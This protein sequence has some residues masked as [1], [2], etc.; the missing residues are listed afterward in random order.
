MDL[1]KA[2]DI[3]TERPERVCDA[4]RGTHLIH[5]QA[6]TCIVRDYTHNTDIILL[7]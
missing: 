1:L 7:I 5:A 2:D 3:G 4:R 6:A